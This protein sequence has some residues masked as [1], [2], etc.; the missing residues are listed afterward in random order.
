MQFLITL[1]VDRLN[2]PP[3]GLEAAMTNFVERELESG[4]FVITGGLAPHADSM[5]ILLSAD[6]MSKGETNLP[7]HGFG[8]VEAA[9]LEDATHVA[10]QILRIHQEYIPDWSGNCEVRPIVTHCLP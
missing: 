2:R 8:V 9:S 5:R 3:A 1:T 6:G 7:V 4:T 10:S